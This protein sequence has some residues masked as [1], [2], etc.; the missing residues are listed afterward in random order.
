MV[1]RQHLPAPAVQGARDGGRVWWNVNRKLDPVLVIRCNG[2]EVIKSS[3]FTRDEGKLS[4]HITLAAGNEFEWSPFDRLEL[5]VLDAGLIGRDLRHVQFTDFTA[6]AGLL[7]EQPLDLLAGADPALSR[8][9]LLCEFLYGDTPVEARRFRVHLEGLKP[10]VIGFVPEDLDPEDLALGFW[11]LHDPVRYARSAAIFEDLYRSGKNP[12]KRLHYLARAL[13]AYFR[14]TDFPRC[15]ELSKEVP[16][17]TG[18]SAGQQESLPPGTDVAALRRL[19]EVARHA[20]GLAPDDEAFLAL[21]AFLLDWQSQLRL[22]YVAGNPAER[23]A[24]AEADLRRWHEALLARLAQDRQRAARLG[25]PTVRSFVT[26]QAAAVE[27]DLRQ[28]GASLGQR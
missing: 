5:Q 24:V 9:Q 13:M 1:H 12:D 3:T 17:D 28:V 19:G 8:V 15:A 21:A 22:E 26:E 6:A 20:A 18:I 14:A 10:R 25:D 16:D 27:K 11:L 23:A 7:D 4:G 2:Q